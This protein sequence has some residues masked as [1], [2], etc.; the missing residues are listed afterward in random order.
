MQPDVL[1]FFHSPTNTVTYLVWDGASKAAVVIDPVLDFDAASAR[2]STDSVHRV[3]TAARDRGL[4][5]E[6]VLE[7]HA[8]ADPI[9][10]GDH[11]RKLT[12]TPVAIGAGIVQVQKTFGPILGS[13]HL[14]SAGSEF[15]RLLVHGK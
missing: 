11:I 7:T 8:H 1:A 12:G 9:S 14:R 10:A 13:D 15:A 2:I 3:L 5:I 4:K 6:W